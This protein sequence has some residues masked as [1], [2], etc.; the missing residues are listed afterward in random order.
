MHIIN[1]ARL[2]AQVVNLVSNRVSR[3]LGKVENSERF[4]R[5]ALYQGVPSSGTTK[6]KRLGA[7]VRV[8]ETDPT[9]VACAHNRPRLFLFTR[10]EPADADNATAGRCGSSGCVERPLRISV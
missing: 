4:L 10:R 8:H 6:T 1:G 2:A 5:L 7:G 9:L 3:I